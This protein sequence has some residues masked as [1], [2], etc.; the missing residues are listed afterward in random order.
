MTY[1]NPVNVE[2]S[3]DPNNSFSST[4]SGISVKA[5]WKNGTT[6]AATIESVQSE[7]KRF[8]CVGGIEFQDN[9]NFTLKRYCAFQ[10]NN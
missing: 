4:Y 6:I 7:Q 9:G 1:K 10:E 3:S 5:T 2:L 8:I